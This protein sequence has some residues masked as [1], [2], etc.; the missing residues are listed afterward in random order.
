MFARTIA[1]TAVLLLSSAAQRDAKAA[2][3]GL[4]SADPTVRTQAACELR[5]MGHGAAPALPQLAALLD[6]GSPVDRTVCG[7]RVQILTRQAFD[8]AHRHGRAAGGGLV[9]VIDAQDALL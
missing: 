4:A 2:A 9:I 5:D 1:V 3:A 6:D 8:H 7:L